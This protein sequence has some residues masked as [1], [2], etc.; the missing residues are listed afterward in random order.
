MKL[1]STFVL[2]S[3]LACPGLAL[4]APVEDEPPPEGR[5]TKAKEPVHVGAYAAAGFP[6]PLTIGGMVWFEKTFSVG[7]EYGT[8]PFSQIGS[9]DVTYR[10]WAGDVRFFPLQS[11]FFFGVRMGKQHVEGS[12]TLSYPPYGSATVTQEADT[13]FV[14]P[15]VGL[16]WTT[17]F[18]LTVG[19]DVGVRIPTRHSSSNNLP[20]GYGVEMPTSVT[21][22]T[23]VLAAKVV[24]TVTLLQLGLQF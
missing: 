5:S 3:V 21:T 19:M 8:L 7:L 18:G 6:A 1:A 4:A 9:V 11:P 17:S 23:D 24:P 22:V 16:L 12:T 14:N 13:W 15:R 20:S 10:S 2:A